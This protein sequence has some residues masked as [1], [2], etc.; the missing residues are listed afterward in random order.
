MNIEYHKWYSANLQKDMELKVYGHKGQP[1]VVFPTSRGRFFDYENMGMVGAISNFIETG[2]IKL[3]SVDSIDAETWYN[4]SILPDDRN[5]RYEAYDHYI[6]NEVIPFVREHCRLPVERIMATGCSMGAY[7]SVNLFLKHPDLFGGVIGLSG[8][9]RLDQP[10]FHLPASELQYVYHN[11]P[12]SFLKNLIDPSYLEW[13]RKSTIIVCTGQGKWENEAVRDT[14]EL[15]TQFTAR[16]IP[17][18]FDYWG[19]DV[20]HDWPWWYKQMNYFLNHLYK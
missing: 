3:F 12:I 10:E 8:L 18:W 11:S 5:A 2:K 6:I 14:R 20:N 17:A 4:L 13:Y 19:F 7:H 1:Y 16:D 15:E 9:Y